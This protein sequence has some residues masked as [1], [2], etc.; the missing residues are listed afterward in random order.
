MPLRSLE[1]AVSLLRRHGAAGDPAAVP[2][3]A[4]GLGTTPDDAVILTRPERLPWLVLAAADP[5][6]TAAE[7]ARRL[8]RRGAPLAVLAT[9]GVR[10]AV[11]VTL[12]RSRVRTVGDPPD[13]AA[14]ALLDA[15]PAVQAE[16]PLPAALRLLA[17]LAQ[18]PA[19]ERFFRAFRAA[20]ARVRDALPTGPRPAERHALALLQLTRVL[21]LY[22]IQAKGWLAGRG[23]FLAREVDACLA[24]GRSVDRHLLRPLC[25]GTLNRPAAAR[26]AAARALGAVPYLNGGLFEPHPLERRFAAAVP[27]AAWRDVFDDC[28]ERFLFCPREA[29]GQAAIAPDMLGRVFEGMMDPDDRDRSGTFYTPAPLVRLLLREGLDAWL[30]ARGLGPLA[31]P[32]PHPDPAARAALRGLTLL[33]P[34]C[35]SGA[36]LLG[37]LELLAAAT[38]ERGE[39]PTAARRRVLR[40]S[41]HGIDLSPVAVRLAEL[42]L[43]L[44]VVADD[45]ARDPAAVQPLPNLDV[46]VREG[47]ALAGAEAAG[48]DAASAARL[49]AARAAFVDA[50]GPAKRTAAALLRRAERALALERLDRAA[51]AEEARIAELL[52]AMRV[53]DLFGERTAARTA[54]ASALREARRRR[55]DARRAARALRQGDAAPPFDVRTQFGDVMGAGG[56]DLVVGNPPWVRGESLAPR[57]RAALA[58]RYRWMRPAGGSGFPGLADLSIAFLERSTSLLPPRGVLAMLVPE[59]LAAARYAAAAR[60]ALASEYTLHVVAPPPDAPGHRFDATAYPMALVASRVPPSAVHEVRVGLDGTAPVV[61]QS[62]LAGG[63]PWIVR[64]P[65]L[66]PILERLRRRHPRLE[67]LLRIRLGVKTGADD[68]FLTDTPDIE[69]ELLRR[70]VRGRDVKAFLVAPRRWLRWPCDAAGRALAALPPC[71]AAHFAR[72]ETTLRQRRD[73]QDGPYWQLFRTA[74]A[75]APHRVVWSDLGG[76][77]RAAAL[78]GR[79]ARTLVPLNT[80]YVAATPSVTAAHALA[81]YLNST[82]VRALAALEAPPAASGFR[83]FTAGVVG[84]LPVPAGLLTDASLACLGATAAGGVAAADEADRHVCAALELDRPDADALAAVARAAPGR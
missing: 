29:D 18:E 52:A 68:V 16:P 20:H 64:S 61:P 11:G 74:A 84:A 45:E 70:A 25:F 80:C 19:G 30:G 40:R 5:A 42:R 44:A 39:S 7:A 35:G 79:D 26:A 34:A 56:F 43:W 77:L 55:A 59:K 66:G 83:R 75:T 67:A 33:D 71:A 32:A 69:A 6:R 53:P 81:A 60:H 73:C 72:H 57:V 12:P 47:D 65:A 22:F 13:A 27:N 15:L 62:R 51:H 58:A 46:L 14:R 82:P 1:A 49:R 38:L 31:G 76:T 54:Q 24:S 3:A 28:F 23:D 41:L 17:V 10:H 78:A 2:P 37:A 8:V 9:D 4:L 21:F 63:G 36:F 48:A 50:A